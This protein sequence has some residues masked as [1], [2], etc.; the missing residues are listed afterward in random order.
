[1]FQTMESTARRTLFY[2]ISGLYHDHVCLLVFYGA[3]SP[4]LLDL[5]LVSSFW[6]WDLQVWDW[7]HI[8]QYSIFISCHLSFLILEKWHCFSL[9]RFFGSLSCTVV[10]LFDRINQDITVNDHFLQ[11]FGGSLVLMSSHLVWLYWEQ[12]PRW[13]LGRKFWEWSIRMILF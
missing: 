10:Q 9:F 8:I 4:S 13:L 6:H 3:W 11:V 1:M 2:I 5:L 12:Y 7:V